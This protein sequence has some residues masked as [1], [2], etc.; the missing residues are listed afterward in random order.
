MEP[1]GSTVRSV[2]K[3]FAVGLGIATLLPL[4]VLYGVTVFH[5]SPDIK[6]YYTKEQDFSTR[7]GQA[8]SEP[9]KQRLSRE[10]EQHQKA[11]E[12]QQRRYYRAVF[13]VGYPVGLLALVAGALVS[14]Q[15]IG[16]GFM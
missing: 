13:Y 10:Q 11:F 15:A 14:I 5:P 12:E 9:E 3:Q 4:T 6:A 7:I 1:N 8:T 16:A 2:P